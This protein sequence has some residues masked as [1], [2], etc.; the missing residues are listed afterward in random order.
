MDYLFK[1]RLLS[2]HNNGACIIRLEGLKDILDVDFI[3]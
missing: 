1:C 2:H 3:L